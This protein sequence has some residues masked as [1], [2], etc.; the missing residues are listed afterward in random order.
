MQNKSKQELQKII[1]E[2][3]KFK[4]R[5]YWAAWNALNDMYNRG[6]A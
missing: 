1:K 5:T 4:N 2:N 3:R 6:D